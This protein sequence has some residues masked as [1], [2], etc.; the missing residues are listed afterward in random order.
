[1]TNDLASLI[2]LIFSVIREKG[3]YNRNGYAMSIRDTLGYFQTE[4]RGKHKY[5]HTYAHTYPHSISIS[6]A[7]KRK[8]NTP[9]HMIC[10]C[11][12]QSDRGE[13]GKCAL[14][15]CA[16]QHSTSYFP[17]LHQQL[18]HLS[19]TLTAVT[20]ILCDSCRLGGLRQIQQAW[21]KIEDKHDANNG[22]DDSIMSGR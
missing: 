14:P 21:G 10:P 3:A 1:M 16:Q 20:S 4:G 18:V 7:S 2:K 19:T 8:S 6:C 15:R 22:D 12:V 9:T 11:G 5:T 13:R 17:H